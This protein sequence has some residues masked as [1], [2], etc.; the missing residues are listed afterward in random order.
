MSLHTCC[1]Q[2]SWCEGEEASHPSCRQGTCR[3]TSCVGGYYWTTQSR[4]IYAPA[5]SR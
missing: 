4:K 5:V 2:N 3:T 1:L